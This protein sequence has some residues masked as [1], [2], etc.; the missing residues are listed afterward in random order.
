[1]KFVVILPL[2]FGYSSL[3]K[4]FHKSVKPADNNP[5]A[6]NSSRAVLVQYRS[7]FEELVREPELTRA[8]AAS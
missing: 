2:G 1:V 7:L 6:L 4:P 3:R 5:H 8:K